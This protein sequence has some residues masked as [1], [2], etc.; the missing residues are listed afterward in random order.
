MKQLTI[1]RDTTHNNL[2]LEYLVGQLERCVDLG[3]K[4]M[5][6]EGIILPEQADMV[7]NYLVESL[8]I[9]LDPESQN[10]EPPWPEAGPFPG[11]ICW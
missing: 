5:V 7:R 6:E 8:N 10:V 1:D 9:A 4:G 2:Q 3:T 11:G